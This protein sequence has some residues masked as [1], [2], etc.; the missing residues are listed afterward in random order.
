MSYLGDRR[1][2]EA[3]AE[4][5]WL[6]A[7]V[8]LVVLLALS[9]RERRKDAERWVAEHPGYEIVWG[10]PEDGWSIEK[11]DDGTTLTESTAVELE[12]R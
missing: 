3:L 5:L 6:A 4:L 12:Q 9:E 10:G 2:R 7:G 8:A 11:V 1:N